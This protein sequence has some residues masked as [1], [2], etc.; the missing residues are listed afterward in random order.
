[1][2]IDQQTEYLAELKARLDKASQLQTATNNGIEIGEAKGE[3]RGEAKA[4]LEAARNLKRLGV[5][6]DIIQQATGLPAETVA[7][8]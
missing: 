2:T 8:L 7:A 4:R 1:M 5:S 3:A 6:D